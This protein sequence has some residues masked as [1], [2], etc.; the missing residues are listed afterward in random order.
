MRSVLRSVA[1][2]LQRSSSHSG[3]F[4]L[5]IAPW[6]FTS[7][8]SAPHSLSHCALNP[9]LL[10]GEFHRRDSGSLS[11]RLQTG[12]ACE[13]FS[14]NL[15]QFA[16]KSA[17]P[18]AVLNSKKTTERHSVTSEHRN[19][20]GLRESFD[21]YPIFCCLFFFLCFSLSADIEKNSRG[22]VLAVS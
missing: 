13:R 12:P 17:C 1:R 6:A 5:E 21:Y 10:C 15:F 7:L 22:F 18:P 14:S 3:S 16:W 11:V 8:P 20:G 4:G 2:R 9:S 19:E